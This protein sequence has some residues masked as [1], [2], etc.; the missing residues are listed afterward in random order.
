[1]QAKVFW[2]PLPNRGKIGILPRPRGADW[3]EDEI[4]AW[5]EAGIDMVVSLLEPEEE[6]QLAL[7]GERVAAGARGIDFRTFPIPDRG[8][9]ASRESVAQLA[10]DV[11]EALDMGRNVA[12]HCRQGIGRSGLIV[13]VVLVAAGEDLGTAVEAISG[14]RGVSVPETEEQRQWLDDF[15][16]WQASRRAAQQAAAADERRSGGRSD[17]R[18]S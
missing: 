11:I 5:R 12:V 2:V 8:V 10:D 9:P 1:M 16:A 13:A 4:A 7:E 15:A 18:P 3:L 17:S 6:A 14:S